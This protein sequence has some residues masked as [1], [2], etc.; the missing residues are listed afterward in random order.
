MNADRE[1]GAREI[2]KEVI[3]DNLP[4]IDPRRV[5]EGKEV[6]IW[7]CMFL[8]FLISMPLFVISLIKFSDEI[9]WRNDYAERE[10]RLSRPPYRKFSDVIEMRFYKQG[11]IGWEIW[12]FMRDGSIK[13]IYP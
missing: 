13:R 9:A 11:Q 6:S 4:L 7:R 3:G 5:Q 10:A 1:K 2:A 8:S 12:G